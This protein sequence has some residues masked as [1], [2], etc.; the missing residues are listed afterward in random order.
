MVKGCTGYCA[1]ATSTA[2]HPAAALVFTSHPFPPSLSSSHWQ[3][4]MED[5]YPYGVVAMG[6]VAVAIGTA[7]L[8][9]MG[10]APVDIIIGADSSGTSTTS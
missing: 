4:Q 8:V 7:A 5:Q 1:Y 3:N 6:M 10:T 2:L 9:A